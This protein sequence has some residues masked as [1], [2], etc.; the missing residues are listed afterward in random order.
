MLLRIIVLHISFFFISDLNASTD[1][2]IRQG[3]REFSKQ[4]I[5]ESIV[6]YSRAIEERPK[7]AL[8][9]LKRAI[10]FRASGQFV[11]Y[12][13]DMQKAL[14]LDPQFTKSYLEIKKINR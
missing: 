8:G 7:H 10:A 13:D 14:R 3:D 11:K 1:Y 6:H 9:Y 4:N 5:E 2:W 12:A